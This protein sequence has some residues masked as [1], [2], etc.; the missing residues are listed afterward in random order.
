MNSINSPSARY[1]NSAVWTGTRML[2]WGGRNNNGIL[3][4]GA[5]YDPVTDTWATLSLG[6]GALAA[7]YWGTTILAGDKV[8]IWGGKGIAGALGDGGVIPP[9]TASL[10]GRERSHYHDRISRSSK[11]AHSYMDG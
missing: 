5:L 3:S 11:Q 2:I 4:D 7:R 6:G 10:G 9:V 1:G 8:L